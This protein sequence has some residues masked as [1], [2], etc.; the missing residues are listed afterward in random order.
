[1][2]TSIIASMFKRLSHTH[3]YNTYCN[4]AQRVSRQSRNDI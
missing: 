3:V 4:W 1:M 2:Q